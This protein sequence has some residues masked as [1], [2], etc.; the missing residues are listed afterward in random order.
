MSRQDGLCIW[1][2][3]VSTHMPHLSKPQA[4]G[5]AL[6]SYGIALT[7]SCGRTTVATFLALLLTCKV[8]SM[9][10][11]L[12]E[13]CYEAPAKAGTKRGI[14]RQA[15]EVTTCFVPLLRWIVRLW[16]GTA[17]ALALDATSLSDRFTVLCVSVVVAGTGIPVAWTILPANQKHAWRREWLRMLRLL[18]PAI[19]P[20]WTVLVLADR[21][22]YAPWLFRRIVRLG[23][24]PFLRINQAAKF[25]PA[26]QARWYWLREL[27]GQ[28]DQRWRG[29]GTAFITQESQ[30]ACTLVAWW[31]AGYKE[32]WFILTDLDPDGCDAAWYGVR[33]WCEQGFKI[34]KRGGWQWQQTR[35]TDPERAARL[36]LAVA[37]ATLW[38][39]SVGTDLEVAAAAALAGPEVAPLLAAAGLSRAGTPRRTRLLRLGC[40]GVL[41]QLITAQPLPLPQHLVP[42][43]WPEIPQ[44]LEP[45]IPHQ[46]AL[47]D[48]PLEKTAP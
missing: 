43:P 32:P 47:S 38:M 6:W 21:G 34:Y 11:R 39:V 24:H 16:H 45:P 10:H 14:K 31:S 5:L 20:D 22:L 35:M 7:R 13:W 9:E 48:V 42:A 26:G 8:G 28:R 2:E 18:R 3:T 46:K 33:T 27:W 29:A 17:L 44:R 4:T 25:R 36:W 12:R 41:V 37:V 30:V 23:W 15:L 40:L 19:P 1:A